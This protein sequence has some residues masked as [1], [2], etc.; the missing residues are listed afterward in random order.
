MLGFTGAFR[1]SELTEIRVADLTFGPHGLS[2]FLPSS[3]A[4]QI[5]EGAVVHIAANPLAAHCPVAAVRA[6]LD[7]ARIEQDW[8]FRRITRDDALGGQGL[9]AESIRLILKQRA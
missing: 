1:R 3:K 9:A 6:W 8:V 4:D 5:G 2:V 7:A